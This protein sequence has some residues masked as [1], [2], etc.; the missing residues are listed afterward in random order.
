MEIEFVR[1]QGPKIQKWQKQ[2]TKFDEDLV[3]CYFLH[4]W[5]FKRVCLGRVCEE[6]DAEKWFLSFC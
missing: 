4:F 6:G 3:G 1:L 5:W 2:A